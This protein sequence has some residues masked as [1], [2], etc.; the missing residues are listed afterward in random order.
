VISTIANSNRF[1]KT[2]FWTGKSAENVI[3]L[4]P[5]AQA[6]LVKSICK[7]SIEKGNYGPFG[8]VFNE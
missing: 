3:I 8:K 1:Q 4:G 2:R 7:R 6:T 5:M